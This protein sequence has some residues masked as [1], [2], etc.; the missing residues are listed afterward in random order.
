MQTAPD[1]AVKTALKSHA[2]TN[3]TSRH[4]ASRVAWQ[5]NTGN[6]G[7]IAAHKATIR[8]RHQYVKSYSPTGWHRLT[9][10]C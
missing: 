10:G 3:L 2:A 6:N 1:R 8:P 4:G 7:D 5:A 9:A